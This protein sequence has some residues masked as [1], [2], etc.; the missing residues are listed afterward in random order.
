MGQS[1][2]TTRMQERLRGLKAKASLKRLRP[3]RAPRLGLAAWVLLALIAA[4]P[5]W[6]M[7]NAQEDRLDLDPIVVKLYSERG[8]EPPPE[9]KQKPA[10]TLPEDW[11]DRFEPKRRDYPMD[12]LA[13]QADTQYR[14]LDRHEYL[15]R[16]LAS[17]PRRKLHVREDRPSPETL[18]I[19]E[20]DLVLAGRGYEIGRFQ[21]QPGLGLQLNTL[22]VPEA[23]QVPLSQ[24]PRYGRRSM[25][26]ANG[27][28]VNRMIFHAGA[29]GI[30]PRMTLEEPMEPEPQRSQQ[31]PVNGEPLPGTRLVLDVNHEPLLLLNPGPDKPVDL[32]N[33]H[34][35]INRHRLEQREQRGK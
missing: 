19:H 14:R 8:M 34:P 9:A 10:S 12:D 6:M 22:P 35:A 1:E 24:L 3:S 30:S 31:K 18:H 27:D 13:V 2:K 23:E 32:L 7:W 33:G 26:S 4:V 20:K 29:S 16:V 11:R 17:A 15:P 5:A 25:E 21:P 28:A